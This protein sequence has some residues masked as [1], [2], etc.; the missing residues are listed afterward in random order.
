MNLNLPLT[1]PTKELNLLANPT[2]E[3]VLLTLLNLLN[4][5]T[6]ATNPILNLLYIYIYIHT[7]TYIHTY[8]HFEITKNID[9]V[10]SSDIQDFFKTNNIPMSM[11]KISNHLTNGGC[12]YIIQ[13][14]G[15]KT[16]KYYK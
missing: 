9:K 1:N 6:N 4:L 11:A 12:V 15:N 10:K 8:K 5:L 13:L 16:S 7:H 14:F 2:D 3:L